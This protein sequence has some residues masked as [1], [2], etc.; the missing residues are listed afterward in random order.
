MIAPYL[1]ASLLLIVTL[2]SAVVSFWEPSADVRPR[3]LFPSA[4]ARQ[5]RL[6][7]G[8][9][10]FILA[11]AFAAWIIIGPRFSTRRPMRF[12]IPEGYRGWVR[13]EFEVP[14]APKLPIE[15]GENV[16]KIPSTGL[17]KTSSPEQYGWSKD[18]YFF[19]SGAGTIPLSDSGS[20]R[21][22]WG[23]LNGEASGLAG[24]RKYEDF[25]VGTQEQYSEQMSGA[26]SPAD[27]K[28]T[29]QPNNAQ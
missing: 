15:A 20:N 12:L 28:H 11:G 10:T 16:L 19:Y 7:A 18:D 2:Y 26:A 22:I 3:W 24:K 8:I 27:Q 1:A 14:G 13:V 23:K 21:L 6:V 17:L 25:F 5:Q 9:A 29:S 4:T